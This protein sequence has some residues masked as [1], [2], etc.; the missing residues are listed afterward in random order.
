MHTENMQKLY[1]YV[2]ESGQ[3]TEGRL[4]LVSVVVLGQDLEPFQKQLEEIELSS[5]KGNRKWF[6]SNAKR[7]EAYIREIIERKPFR[8]SIFYSYYEDSKAYF[9]LTVFSTAKAVL[10]KACG[11]YET[12]VLVDGPK[13]SERHRFSAGLRRLNIRVR[14]VRGVRKDENEPLIRLADAIAGFVRDFL[15]G[16]TVM[17]DLYQKAEARGIIQ[18]L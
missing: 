4:F 5:R 15:E 6:H 7:R 13:R 17:K 11:P 18:R 8:G 10:N 12:T 2:D 16:N 9:D 1:C 3:D 14:K